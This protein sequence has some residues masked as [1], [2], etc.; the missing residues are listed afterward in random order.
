MLCVRLWFYAIIFR[1]YLMKKLYFLSALL[2]SLPVFADCVEMAQELVN[3]PGTTSA[4]LRDRKYA[5]QTY[6]AVCN[7]QG[8]P[9]FANC[10]EMAQEL[11]NLPGTTNADLMNRKYAIQAYNAVCNG[12]REQQEE[13]RPPAPPV[14]QYVPSIRQWCQQQGGEIHCWN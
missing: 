14:P 9:A 1:G 3:L 13:V 8:Q 7:G 10:E 5:I 2:L 11:V 4:D 6:N 12:G